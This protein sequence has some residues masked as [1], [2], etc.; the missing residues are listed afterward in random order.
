M[1]RSP[2]KIPAIMLTIERGH[3]SASLAMSGNQDDAVSDE[4][5]LILSTNPTVWSWAV[6]T[7]TIV[8]S[9]PSLVRRVRLASLILNGFQG[10]WE[11]K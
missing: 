7:T 8:D 3:I 11:G 1:R 2:A 5:T 4:V 10:E 9:Q 6:P